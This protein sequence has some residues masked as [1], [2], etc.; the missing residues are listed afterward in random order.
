VPCNPVKLPAGGMAIVCT[1]G[2]RVKQCS[3]CSRAGD[4]LCDFPVERVGKAGTCDRSI[5]HRCSTRI[6]GE[7][8]L[9][10]AH[11]PL[12]DRVADRALVGPG[13]VR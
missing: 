7:R 10:R 2:R 4:R 13:A 1:R 11:A 5:C 12:W 8:D 6:S 9:C 3:S